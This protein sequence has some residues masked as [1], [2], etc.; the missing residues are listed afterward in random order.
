MSFNH[1]LII[2]KKYFEYITIKNA[3]GKNK[4]CIIPIRPKFSKFN[5]LKNHINTE[6][7]NAKMAANAIKLAIIQ[8]I[9]VNIFE[10]PIEMA[11]KKLLAPIFGKFLIASMLAL[12]LLVSGNIVLETAKAPGAAIRLAIIKWLGGTPNPIYAYKNKFS[13]YSKN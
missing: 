3:N 13:I 8:L 9:G 12:V 4:Y 6:S 11:S 7:I 5:W 2:F 10:A 1:I